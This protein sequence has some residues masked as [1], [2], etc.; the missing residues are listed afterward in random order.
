MMFLSITALDGE[1]AHKALELAGQIGPTRVRRSRGSA[2]SS[3]AGPPDA[4]RKH[5]N[6]RTGTIAAPRLP[7][8]REQRALERRQSRSQRCLLPATTRHSTSR[9]ARPKADVREGERSELRSAHNLPT[10]VRSFPTGCRSS[11]EPERSP[12]VMRC[13]IARG[14]GLRA[15]PTGASDHLDESV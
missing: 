2:I 13:V 9:I 8:S 14:R 11:V 12:N 10:L 5:E 6:C 7:L 4:G 1:C 15:M 3:P